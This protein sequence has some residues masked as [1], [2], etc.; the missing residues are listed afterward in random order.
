MRYNDGDRDSYRFSDHTG[1]GQWVFPTF[2]TFD[3]DPICT[4]GMCALRD[5]EFFELD[6]DLAVLGVSGDGIHSHERFA[7]HHD[8]N[9]PLLSDTVKDV[10]DQ[11]GVVRAEYEGMRRVHQRAAF[12]IDDGRTVRF[13]TTMDATSPNDIELGPINDV[14]RGLRA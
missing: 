2:Y 5:A 6:D 12:T 3:F 11:Y 1:A 8:S 4:A 13:A 10:A 14:L 7:E 9:Y